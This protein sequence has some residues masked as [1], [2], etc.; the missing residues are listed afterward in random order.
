MTRHRVR[1]AAGIDAATAEALR[2]ETGVDG[3]VIA[4]VELSSDAVPPK[5][6]LI[7]RLVSI[8]AA[9][10]VV[11]ADDAGMSGDDAPGLLRARR[12]QRLRDAADEGLESP[13][14][15]RL[16]RFLKT[17]AAQSDG[18]GA[19]KFRPKTFYRSLRVEPGQAVLGCSRAVLQ[20]ERAAERRRDPGVAVHAGTCPASPQFRVVDTG[21]T[22]QQLL[23][24]R[25]IMDGGLSISDAETVA[26]ADRRGLRAGRAGAPLP[27]LRRARRARRSVEFST[28]LIEKNS[29]QGRVQFG[30]LQRRTRRR[31]AA[32]S[33]GP[34]RRRTPW[35]RRW[36]G[37]RPR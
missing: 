34:R 18:E 21:V 14:A 23:N 17:G 1:Y 22:R 16:V 28:V 8:Q 26:S 9:P 36:S 30:Q 4:S 12:R 25:I 13:G 7:V 6:A 2:Q 20:P 24:A 29:R 3:V 19:S 35:P 10:T 27:G 37:S 5:V 32:S 31:R 11:W 33:A 15:I